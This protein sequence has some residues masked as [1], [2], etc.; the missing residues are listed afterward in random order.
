MGFMGY[1]RPDGSVG[2]RNHVAV[3]GTTSYASGV[4]RAIAEAV[5]GVKA[6]A[7]TEGDGRSSEDLSVTA[8]TLIGLGSNPNVAAALVIGSGSERHGAREITEGIRRTGKPVEM[9]VIQEE[10]GSRT[11]TAKGLDVVRT[12][13][14]GVRDVE[15]QRFGWERL[16]IAMKCGGSDALSGITANPSIGWFADWLVEQGGTVLLGEITEMI[17]TE[18]ILERRAANSTI[19]RRIVDLLDEQKRTA[20]AQLGALATGATIAPGNVAGGI[21]SIQEKSLGCIAKGGTTPIRGVV[22]YAERPSEHGLHIMDTPG[23]D[24]F[25]ITGMAAGGAQIILFSTGRGSPAGFPIVPVVKVSTNTRIWRDLNDDIDIDAGKI[26]D[27]ARVGDVGSELVEYVG[28]VVSGNPTKA[29]ANRYDLLAIHASGPAVR[30][31]TSARR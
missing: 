13:V 16:T 12:L 17:G 27:G 3:I 22:A 9:L 6:L 2:I 8:R 29:E 18:E 11:T 14:K 10:G 15:R 1:L 31:S 5:D 19:G 7:H 20:A 23:S 28:K 25:S 26:I 21:T 24:I 30:A 4:V